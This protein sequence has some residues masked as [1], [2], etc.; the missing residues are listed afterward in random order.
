MYTNYQYRRS[1]EPGGR[2][3]HCIME[4]WAPVIYE[5]VKPGLYLVS[6]LG[7]VFSIPKND[8]LSPVNTNGY[9][10]VG[11]QTIDGSRKTCRIHRLVATAFIPNPDP[12]N[13]NL[14]NHKNLLKYDNSVYNLE[15]VNHDENMEHAANYYSRED[16][17]SSYIHSPK[18]DTNNWSRGDLTYGE[19]NGMSVWRE[20]QVHIMC[21]AV[22]DGNNYSTALYLAGIEDT[23]NN[24]FNLS[25]IIQGK[26]WK[27]IADQY[28]LNPR[29]QKNYNDFIIPVCELLVQGLSNGEIVAA[30]GCLPGTD[31]QNRR[32]IAR[33][34]NRKAYTDVS[35]NYNW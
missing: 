7:R 21:K 27:H 6:T 29:V 3:F 26:R 23:E 5:D 1:T 35:C 20:E 19:N 30:I 28:N 13:K 18:A 2:Q 22:Q 24:R 12:V 8:F 33:I 31:D 15:W 25:H 14:V 4:Q 10:E 9:L 32:F 17:I 11:M 34:R 16:A